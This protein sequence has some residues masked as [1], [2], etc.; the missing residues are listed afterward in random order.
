MFARWF[1]GVG[2]IGEQHAVR[3]RVRKGLPD[4]DVDRPPRARSDL[5]TL[6]PSPESADVCRLPAVERDPARG[7]RDAIYMT[8]ILCQRRSPDTWGRDVKVKLETA[9]GHRTGGKAHRGAGMDGQA[10][11]RG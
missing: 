5:F 7:I 10:P 6:K 1:D 9:E 2:R 3:N 4:R 11:D 8:L